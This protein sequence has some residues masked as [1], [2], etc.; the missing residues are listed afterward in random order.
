MIQPLNHHH[1]TLHLSPL[2]QVRRHNQMILIHNQIQSLISPSPTS[3]LMKLTPIVRAMTTIMTKL[4]TLRS[5][6]LILKV[7]V[8][9]SSGLFLWSL[10][11]FLLLLYSLELENADHVKIIEKTLTCNIVM[12]LRA[13][14]MALIVKMKKK[15]MMYQAIQKGEMVSENKG[16]RV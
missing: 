2:I 16:K 13:L 3:L 7:A 10:R 5:I 8:Q 6:H 11:Y 1:T 14:I 12:K 15:V 4:N 9:T